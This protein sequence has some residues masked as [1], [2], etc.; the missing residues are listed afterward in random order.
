MLEEKN[1]LTKNSVSGKLSFKNEREIKILPDKQ[2]WVEFITTRP[3]LQEMLKSVL[4]VE[5]KGY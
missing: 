2:K 5:M 1:L 4:Q 3:N